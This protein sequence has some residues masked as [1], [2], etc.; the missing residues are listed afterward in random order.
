MS[1]L[2][3]TLTQI[4]LNTYTYG[5]EASVWLLIGFLFAGLLRVFMPQEF[6]YK[7][8]GKRGF[9]SI[10]TATVIGIPLPLCS[11]GV[12]PVGVGLYR[13]GASKASTLAFFISTPAT[14][15]TTILI[16]AGMLGWRFAIAEVVLCFAVAFITGLLASLL[17]GKRSEKSE[18]AGKVDVRSF[19]EASYSNKGGKEKIVAVFRYGF[20]DM[21]DD[22]G[23]YVLIGLFTAGVVA[24]L[25]PSTFIE[26]FLGKGIIPLILMVLIGTPMYIC[27]TASVPFVAALVAK[28]MHSAAGLV[29]LVAG[30]ATNLSTILVVGKS[31]GK[32][33]AFLYVASIII[34]SVLF[35]Y[36]FCLVGWV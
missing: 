33:T 6:L 31:M 17:L 2:S 26:Q 19:C 7:H 21:V 35:A 23:L 5:R 27:S 30:P 34:F 15:V 20:I 24:T 8:L 4:A 11:C 14:T 29:F 16:A 32:E 12:I 1:S 3:E 28:G 10:L 22:I 9:R 13:Q 18:R 36:G 25:I